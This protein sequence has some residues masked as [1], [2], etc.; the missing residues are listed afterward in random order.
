MPINW[1]NLPIA[2]RPMQLDPQ[3]FIKLMRDQFQ[4]EKELVTMDQVFRE[5]EEW[6]SMQA[7]IILT[8]IDEAYGITIEED[9]L[10][11]AKTFS[12]LYNLVNQ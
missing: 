8:C 7:L 4:T 5:L 3:S 10:R 12:D 11:Q 2:K 9:K 1:P 6:S